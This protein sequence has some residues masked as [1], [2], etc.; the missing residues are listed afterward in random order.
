MRIIGIGR[1]HR[2]RLIHPRQELVFQ[3][4][5]GL[6]QSL[7]PSH[8]QPLHQPV[9]RRR[10]APFHT[11]LRLRRMRADP[12]NLQF[13]ER[14]RD[15]CRR[16]FQSVLLPLLVALG[17]HRSLKQACF[18]GVAAQ[19]P[20]PLFQVPLQHLHVLFGRVVP[21]KTGMPLAAGII[22]QQDQLE[23]IPSSLQPVMVAGVPL[24]QIPKAASPCPPLM[25][26][27]YPFFFRPP[28][29]GFD[30]PRPHRL[31]AHL[32]LVLLGQILA[33]QRRPESSVHLLR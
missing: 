20:P 33:G 13:L 19:R 27:P 17:L 1:R 7:R 21:H 2:Q 12:R 32:H 28:Q 16:H 14:P 4:L 11:P 6:L 26:L 24:Q 25:N 10:K 9:L 22:D 29:L 30:H 23:L 8:A 5:I 31:P 18:I 15:L 3:M